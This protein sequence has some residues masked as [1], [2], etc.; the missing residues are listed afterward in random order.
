MV[1]PPQRSVKVALTPPPLT[2]YTAA[3]KKKKELNE[4]EKAPP[5]RKKTLIEV[6]GK[7]GDPSTSSARGAGA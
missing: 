4:K 6:E 3:A 2:H 7:K 5:T 1:E